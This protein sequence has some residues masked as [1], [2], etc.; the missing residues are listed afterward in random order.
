MQKLILPAILIFFILS[1]AWFLGNTPKPLAMHAGE[2]DEQKPGYSRD[3]YEW[4]LSRDPRTGKIP[5]GIRKRELTWVASAPVRQSGM[6]N[7][8]V[9]NVYQAVGPSVN[10]GRTRALAFDVRY[11]GGSNRVV[12][13]GGVNGGIFRSEDGGV[14]WTFVHPSNEVRS[15]TCIAQDP[16]PGSQDTWYAGTGEG[17]QT[18]EWPNAFVLGFGMLK[19]TD[20]GKTWTKLAST[21]TGSEFSFDS[22]FDLNHN[23]AVH[24]V[25]GDVYVAGQEAILRSQNGGIN[26]SVLLRGTTATNSFGGFTDILI[27]KAGT[28]LFA[29]LSGR[30]PDRAI[31]GVWT[32]TT[33]N[34]GSWTRVAGGAQNQPD[35]VPGWSA[36]NSDLSK[37]PN[38]QGWGRIVLGF[39]AN[40]DLLVLMTNSQKSESNQS[41]ADLFRANTTTTP[42]TWSANLG[43]NI[44]AKYTNTSGSED[45]YFKTYVDG[46][47]M[48]VAGHP[49]QNNVIYIGGVFLYKSTDGFQTTANNLLIGGAEFD[50]PS[51]TFDDPEGASHVDF[52]NLKFDPTNPNRLITA[53]DGGIAITPDALSSKP[54]WQIGNKNYQTFQ[55]YFVGIDQTPGSRNYIGG[56]QDN[57]ISVRDRSGFTSSVF[58][59]VLPDSN[60]HYIFPFG[61]GAQTYIANINSGY[62]IFGSALFNFAYRIKTFSPIA[63][64][65]ITPQDIST[66]EDNGPTYYHLDDDNPNFLYFPSRDSIYRTSDAANVTAAT[67]WTRM[68]GVDPVVTG[69]I[70]SMATTRGPYSPGSMLL[71]GTSEGKIYRLTDPA[72]TSPST[73]PVD[74]TPSGMSAGYLVK[75]I[76]INP[77]NQDTVMAVVSN[78]NVS[79]IFWTGNAT[80]ANPTWQVIEGNLSLPSVRACE[81]VAKNTGVEYY[82]GTSVGLFS[83]A[84]IS[85]ASTVWTRETGGPGGMMNT[86]IINS[87]AYRW[88]D[89]TLLVGTH[90]NGMFVA[91]IGGAINLPTGINDPIRNDRNFIIK[92]FP[93]ITNGIINYQAGNLLNIKSIQVQVINLAGQVLYNQKAAYGSGNINISTFPRGMYILTITSNDRKYQFIR[94][95]NKG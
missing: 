41:E 92:A 82:A 57:G 9:N 37:F 77:R 68:T 94:K 83:T 3:R 74:I 91:N 49:T 15:V 36:Y 29:A 39:T 27:N 79:S 73:A 60:D 48:V 14:T 54:L 44:V 23:I 85:G 19:S 22:F 52:H 87:L 55:Y 30:N 24:P 34:P 59:P 25:T 95:F 35:S 88:K 75:D 11:N 18:A 90:S 93:T 67:G 4:L 81:I 50:G 5:D 6:M 53:S 45:K 12:L 63:F 76:S 8:L 70:Y 2:E 58:G 40:E 42:F 17:N 61:D 66:T 80:A 65:R 56:A 31:A 62:Y 84:A 7:A 86:N 43:Q 72:N 47:N 46:F 32:S 21:A 16:R 71:I 51:D 69:T 33:G 13:S 26:W 89:N 1:G 38:T 10:G 64:V 20:N 78:Y 28:K